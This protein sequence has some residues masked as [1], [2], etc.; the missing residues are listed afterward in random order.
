MSYINLPT[1][2]PIS[3]SK[4]RGQIQV[5]GPACGGG[6]W[7]L[8]S[9]RGGTPKVPS[10]LGDPR[11]HV[12]RKKVMDESSGRVGLLSAHW[13]FS[14]AFPFSQKSQTKCKPRLTSG[15]AFPPKFLFHGL[16]PASRPRPFSQRTIL[17]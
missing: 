11:A 16:P 14:P 6:G 3:P 2:L 7:V 13:F 1:V 5:R 8:G 4:T 9:A 17:A 12:L 15:R 10:L